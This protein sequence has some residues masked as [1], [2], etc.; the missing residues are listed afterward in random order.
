MSLTPTGFTTAAK[1]ITTRKVF[2][3]SW[4][5][6]WPKKPMVSIW[7]RLKREFMA[8]LDIQIVPFLRRC[9]ISRNLA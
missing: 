4:I 1:G 5:S 6:E 8:E 9:L 7:E 2:S 3:V